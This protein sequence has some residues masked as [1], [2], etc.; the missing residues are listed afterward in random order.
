[1]NQPTYSLAEALAEATD[2]VREEHAMTMQR[3]PF[4]ATDTHDAI[5]YVITMIDRHGEIL[6]YFA[7]GLRASD[8]AG[9]VDDQGGDPNVTLCLSHRHIEVALG[10]LRDVFDHLT[11]AQNNLGHLGRTEKD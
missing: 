8:G 5:G 3:T 4:E 2:I 6:D 10:H 7:T 9:Y 11:A 1:M